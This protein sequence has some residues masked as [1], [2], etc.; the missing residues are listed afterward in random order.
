MPKSREEF[1]ENDNKKIQEKLSSAD[2]NWWKIHFVH[3]NIN[4]VF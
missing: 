4:V 3:I 2:K 1:T